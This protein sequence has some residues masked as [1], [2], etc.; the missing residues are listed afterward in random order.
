LRAEL[1]R[2]RD[3]L[4]RRGIAYVVVVVPEKYSV[5]PEYLPDH[6]ARVTPDTPL[7]RIV[8]ALAQHP[9]LFFVDLRPALRAAKARGQL[10]YKSDSR[11]TS[12]GARVGYEALAPV[13]AAALPG[14][15]AAPPLALEPYTVPDQY[16]SGDL[17]RMLGLPREFRER[18]AV[19]FAL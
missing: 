8:T 10:Y 17:A 16:Y 9:E 13:L 2:R 11:W 18:D 14:L 15:R 12:P 1:L 6:V 3:A 19:P 5:Y 4:A 7:D